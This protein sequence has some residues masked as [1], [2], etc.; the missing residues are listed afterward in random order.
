MQV[1]INIDVDDLERA[2]AFYRSALGLQ[3][4]RRLFADTVAEM[5][6]AAA[7]IHLLLKS[8]GSMASMNAAVPRDYL[9]HWTPVH[10]DFVVDDLEIAVQ[11]AR[12]A[13]AVQEGGIQYFN[14]GRFATMSDPF[15]N[16]FCLLQLAG[17]SY[18]DTV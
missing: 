18:R 2:V 12:D 15:G 13:G 6:G 3:E 7:P 5:L 10:L 8:Q 11:T 14:G 17:G 1:L 16:G 9:R 4:G